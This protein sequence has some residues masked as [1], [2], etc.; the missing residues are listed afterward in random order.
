MMLTRKEIKKLKLSVKINNDQQDLN[1][2]LFRS[3]HRRWNG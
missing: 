1:H 2:E 3:K